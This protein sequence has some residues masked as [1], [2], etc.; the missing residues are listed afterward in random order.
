MVEPRR[1]APQNNNN[2]ANINKNNGGPSGSFKSGPLSP[3]RTLADCGGGT[4][5]GSLEIVVPR[6][7]NH[8]QRDGFGT[9]TNDP[10]ICFMDL[11]NETKEVKRSIVID[12]ELS[13]DWE[14]ELQKRGGISSD[15]GR[16][17]HEARIYS[18]LLYT[19]PS[20]RDS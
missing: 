5:A 4:T 2:N 1:R 8:I 13:P 7:S 6:G 3:Q 10:Y 16:K 14:K 9:G 17:F 19:S 12:D 11:H 18:C 20:P 15:K